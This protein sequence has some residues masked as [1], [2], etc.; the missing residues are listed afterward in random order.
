M[1]RTV[2]VGICILFQ[3]SQAFGQ[4]IDQ[5][6]IYDWYD[7]KTNPAS[8]TLYNG[9]QYINEFVVFKDT[10]HQFYNTNKFEKGRV[11][12]D[13]KYFGSVFLKYDLYND[14]LIL[15]PS[16]SSGS[17]P[18]KLLKS[19]VGSFELNETRFVNVDKLKK[20]GDNQK[21]GFCEFI[22]GNNKFE[23]YKK[24][25]K[26][27]KEIT[28]KNR[29]FYEFS[30]KGRFYVYFKENF[31]PADDKT[32]WVSLFPEHKETIRAFFK[33]ARKQ[34]KTNPAKFY[35]RLSNLINTKLIEE[36]TNA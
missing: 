18:F 28:V 7:E 4:H 16:G 3:T 15:A 12:C 20:V 21:V 31:Y 35:E 1:L 34:L 11:V 25:W 10:L 32:D 23:L 9:V 30:E 14:D 27:K 5:N 13:N 6:A 8:S 22:W 29:R 36:Q 26:V 17:F 24:S 2:L 19:N 33:D